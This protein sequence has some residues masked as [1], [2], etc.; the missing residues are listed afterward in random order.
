MKR[1]LAVL[2]ISAVSSCRVEVGAQSRD[3]AGE[4]ATVRVYSSIYKHVIDAIQPV[5][6][7]RLR[8]AGYSAVRVEWFQ[9]G[10]EKVAARL[11]AELASGGSP[12]DLLLT[13]DPTYYQRLKHDGN[14]VPY[15]SPAS[16]KYPLQYLDRDGA[17]ALSRLSTMALAVSSKLPEGRV[18]A[19]FRDLAK[20]GGVRVALGDPLASGTTLT[21][22]AAIAGRYGWDWFRAVKRA[23]GVVVGG[24]AAVLQRVESG[25]SDVG[26]VLLENVL[27]SRARGSKVR[28]VIPSDGAV[29]IPGPIALLPH[30]A[31]SLAA[32]AVYDALLSDEVQRILIDPGLLHSPNP[33]LPPPPG[34][35]PLRELLSAQFP[36]S[37]EPPAQVKAAFNAI[38]FQ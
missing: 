32:R 11:D 24:N 21:A 36:L 23:R 37:P 15:I 1:F 26:I 12:C 13:S 14:L 34:A 27:A 6:A 2:L 29:I 8:A 10:S 9:S 7:A 4:A 5:L 30:G 31:R 16:L 25:E 3:A 35:P 17:F 33:A 18:P 38:F 28:L 20:G 22:V 19:S